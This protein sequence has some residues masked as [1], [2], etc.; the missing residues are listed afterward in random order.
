MT[1]PKKYKKKLVMT[2]GGSSGSSAGPQGWWWLITRVWLE[3]HVERWRGGD[4]SWV[5]RGPRVTCDLWPPCWSHDDTYYKT[6]KTLVLFHR[7]EEGANH[8]PHLMSPPQ[9][10]KL[11]GS[12]SQAHLITRLARESISTASTNWRYPI[13]WPTILELGIEFPAVV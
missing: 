5:G 11:H 6:W 13:T 7:C 2:M 12:T 9:R 4:K 1:P 3:S 10:P 8:M